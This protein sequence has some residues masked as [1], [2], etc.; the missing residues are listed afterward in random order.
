MKK[1]LVIAAIAAALV[2][3]GVVAF[4]Q[5]RS[6]VI[7]KQRV[8]QEALVSSLLKEKR[9]R[10]ALAVLQLLRHD[11]A[12]AQ[13]ADQETRWQQWELAATVQLRE[14][15]RL[16]ALYE[17]YPALVQA[18]EAASLLATRALLA[19][20]HPAEAAKL[21]AAWHGHEHRTADW[22]C[23]DADECVSRKKPEEAVALLEGTHLEG[24]EDC[25]RLLRL[26]ILSSGQPKKVWTYFQQAYAADP[27]NTDLRS[28]RGQVLENAGQFPLARAEY[29][30]ALAIDP[31]N[32]LLR[33][34]LADFYT[35]QRDYPMTV[36]TLAGGMRGDTFDFIWLKAAFWSRLA[37]PLPKDAP[38]AGQ[39]PQGALEPLVKMIAALPAGQFW[40]E[41][42]FQQLRFSTQYNT[43]R[44]EVFWLRLLQ[45]LKEGREKEAA[46]L[47]AA[48]PFRTRSLHP[49][50][51]SSLRILLKC[52]LHQA[53][54]MP[55]DYD[56][57]PGGAGTHSF[58]KAVGAWSQG[59]PEAGLESFATGPRAFAGALLAAGWLE[60]ALEFTPTDRALAGAPEWFTY[61]M[62]RA[63]SL[64]RSPEAALAF[65]QLQ[66]DS[67]WMRLAIE[68]LRLRSSLE[69]IDNAPAVK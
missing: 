1:N 28:F 14:P 12:G 45:L 46:E 62:T 38:A 39:C 44:Q 40:D 66:P 6:H 30:A 48:N 25:V 29:S 23:Y 60:A 10:D 7:L 24:K 33:D 50:L 13:T 59:H 21:R 64:N 17:R 11:A 34:Q 42:A 54:P 26:A 53:A 4:S 52:R 2:T 63:L 58:F 19:S 65:A 47:L 43:G 3:G 61:D 37:S 16:I 36:A 5:W 32:P 35:R 41:S 55:G 22:L 56:S 8:R 27:Q 20:K 18:D 15:P 68:K 49:E 57:G 69:E 9:I 31:T 51:E 67:P